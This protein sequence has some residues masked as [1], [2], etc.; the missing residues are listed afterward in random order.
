MDRYGGTGLLFSFNAQL[1]RL[2]IGERAINGE[3]SGTIRG[4]LMHDTSYFRFACSENSWSISTGFL[5]KF[6]SSHNIKQRKKF[7]TVLVSLS[8][9]FAEIQASK[10][11]KKAVGK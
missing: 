8:L 4:C 3:D 9:A 10:K 7:L 6:F 2:S 1:N 11:T 5:F